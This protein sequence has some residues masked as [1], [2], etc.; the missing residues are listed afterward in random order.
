MPGPGYTAAKV[1]KARILGSSGCEVSVSFGLFSSGPAVTVLL[2][3]F[4]PQGLRTLG[5]I[6]MQ[7]GSQV[8]QVQASN[9]EFVQS[10]D[11]EA[12]SSSSNHSEA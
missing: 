3:R 10:P 6:Q 9:H 1:T 11:S 4:A 2:G 8:A 7:L 12:L 5:Y